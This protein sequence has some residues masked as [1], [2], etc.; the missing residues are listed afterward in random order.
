MKSAESCFK[1]LGLIICLAF[2]LIGSGNSTAQIVLFGVILLSIG[3]PHGAID[4]LTSQPR[5]TKKSLAKFLLIYLGLMGF[6]LGVW[7][8]AAKLAMLLFLVFSAYH[9]G[10]THFLYRCENMGWHG[11]LLFLS[12]GIFLLSVIL[13]GSFETTAEILSSIVS[14][15]F[16]ERYTFYLILIFFGL[17]TLIQAISKT[18]FEKND[19]LDLFVLPVLLYFSPL[20][21]G[22]GVYFGFWHSLPS[23]I[24]E[25]AYLSEFPQYQGI[26]KFIIQLLPFSLISLAGIGIVLFLGI[27]SMEMGQLTL[28]FFVLISLI[29]FPH[30]IY[31]D[32]FFKKS[33]KIDSYST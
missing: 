19:L 8:F 4:H 33:A 27:N 7:F 2:I 21:V 25:Y 11:P 10:Q 6:Y 31:M 16:L 20:F 29:S 5:L 30:V 18:K 24:S 14:I 28:L 1:L 15:G 22:F 23:M 3:I 9:F 13:F 12:R 26:K 17:T 32:S